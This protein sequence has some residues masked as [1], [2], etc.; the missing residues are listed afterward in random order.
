MNWNI[1]RY[2]IRIGSRFKSWYRVFKLDVLEKKVHAMR[3]LI[4]FALLHR[5]LKGI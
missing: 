1:N 5:R 4:G 2:G 3:N